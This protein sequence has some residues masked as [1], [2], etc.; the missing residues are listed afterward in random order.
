ML[1]G[2]G[3]NE[4]SFFEAKTWVDGSYEASGSSGGPPLPQKKPFL[5]SV[6]CM[7]QK[8]PVHSVVKQVCLQ[9]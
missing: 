7:N 2:E 3:V 8:G 6:L 9:I 1:E 5:A 4:E